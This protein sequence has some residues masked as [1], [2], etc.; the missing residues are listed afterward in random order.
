MWCGVY[1]NEK[2]HTHTH[3]HFDTDRL[4]NRQTIE[5]VKR[6]D[7]CLVGGE[8]KL[9]LL[10]WN[11]FAHFCDILHWGVYLASR[12]KVEFFKGRKENIL[13]LLFHLFISCLLVWLVVCLFVCSLGCCCLWKRKILFWRLECNA[14]IIQ[15]KEFFKWWQCYYWLRVEFDLLGVTFRCRSKFS[16]SMFSGVC[17]WQSTCVCGCHIDTFC[18][19][20]SLSLS[21]SI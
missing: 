1:H 11:R 5:L 8:T 21:L 7:L 19:N 9:F 18:L 15:N 4:I 17:K 14:E 3:T 13:H 16:G 12:I 2:A 20:A 10:Q 6:C